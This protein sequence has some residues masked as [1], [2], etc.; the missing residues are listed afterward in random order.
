MDQIYLA[1]IQHGREGRQCTFS[2]RMEG[3][4]RVALLWLVV[5]A[6]KTN[7]LLLIENIFSDIF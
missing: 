2:C 3:R 6:I 1:I 7:V 5:K 4:S